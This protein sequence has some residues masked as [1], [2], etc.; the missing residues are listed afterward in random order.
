MNTETH[1]IQQYLAPLYTQSSTYPLDI[2]DDCAVI[3]SKDKILTSVDSSVE[4][5]HF[6]KDLNPY[7]VAYRSVAVAISDILAM[8][9]IP[10][11][12]LLSIS[13]PQPSDFW[14]RAFS[15]GIEKVNQDYDLSL[16]GGDLVKGQLTITVTAFGRA[17]ENICERSNAKLG[18]NIFL[19]GALGCGKAGLEDYQNGVRDE[20][21]Q[22]LMP[23]LVS[24]QVIERL[25]PL[26]NAAID[27]SDG[28]VKDLGRICSA[29]GVGAKIFISDIF[30]DC[31][32]EPLVAGDDYV[33][34]FTSSAPI[35]DIINIDQHIHCIGKIIKGNQVLVID[36]EGRQLDME[37]DGWDSFIKSC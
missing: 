21:S 25:N 12:Y 23:Q 28:L 26:M 30:Y 17:L 11:S 9:G 13:H 32:E 35:E 15:K 37:R 2:G 31:A 33:L 14:F 3:N 5:Q 4:E 16:I 10:E 36:P 29:S 27:V 7:Y 18:D 22:Y 24:N 34:C 20:P 6:P 8:G 1:Y 19:S